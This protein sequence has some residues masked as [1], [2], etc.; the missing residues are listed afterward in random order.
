MAERTERAVLNRLKSNGAAMPNVDSA[1][2]P[3]RYTTPSC[4]L[5]S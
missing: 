4:G 1:L 3:T 5:A 2:P